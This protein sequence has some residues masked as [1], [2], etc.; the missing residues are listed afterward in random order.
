MA[1]IS[2]GK[3]WVDNE[4]VTYTD[5]NGNF[6]TIYNDYNGGITNDNISASAAIVESK[7]TFNTSTGHSHNGTDSKK[8]TINRGFSWYLDGTQIVADE[9]GAKYIVP[10]D[11]T[12]VKVWYQTGSGTATLRLQHGTTTIVDSLS[13]SS[14]QSSAT[15]FASEDLTAGDT[16]TLDITAC[17]S[18]ANISV[19]LEAEQ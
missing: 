9:V 19:T 3:S 13:A 14:T 2:K 18:G 12:V 10:Q 16:L 6:D 5:L 17:S 4:N 8:I 1:T 7:I 11:M 15:V